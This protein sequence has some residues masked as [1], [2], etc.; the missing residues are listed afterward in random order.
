[1]VVARYTRFRVISLVLG[2]LIGVVLAELGLR[3]IGLGYSNSPPIS[4]PVLHHKHPPDYESVSFTPSG[5][6]GG[7]RVRY[8]SQGL[9]S[10]PDGDREA[11]AAPG[12]RFRVAFMGDSF[13]E[14][15]QVPWAS[16][17]VG[18]LGG[19]VEDQALVK[20]FGVTG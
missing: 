17:F 2:S 7:H 12:P 13:V 1:M 15:L 19:R 14:A 3:V 18:L 6:Y 4:D 11:E 9:V 8:D 16:S 20:N 5:E 10:D